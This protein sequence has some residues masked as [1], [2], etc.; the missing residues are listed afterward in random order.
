M[1][2]ANLPYSVAQ[3]QQAP[4][5]R[6][7]PTFSWRCSS[8]KLCRGMGS[9][10]RSLQTCSPTATTHATGCSGQLGVCR[11]S[12][13][14][15]ASPLLQDGQALGMVVPGE[16]GHHWVI[17]LQASVA[18]HHHWLVPPALIGPFH[19]VAVLRVVL[20]DSSRVSQSVMLCEGWRIGGQL[21]NRPPA[22]LCRWLPVECC[23]PA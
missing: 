1:L 14:D 21:V 6:Q 15:I 16:I 3:V 19:V 10:L 5:M 13:K 23:T 11:R 12:R 20:Q 2:H 4:R 7:L 17:P 8:L 9:P 18:I 22:M